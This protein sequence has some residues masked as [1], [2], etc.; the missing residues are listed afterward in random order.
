MKN[1]IPIPAFSNLYEEDPL[2]D[3]FWHYNM[4]EHF[5]AARERMTDIG[6][7]AAEATPFSARADKFGPVLHTHSADGELNER[8]EYHPDYIRLREL[9]YG[10]G[11]INI[12]YDAESLKRFGPVRHRLGFAMGYYFAQTEIG[13]YCPVCMTDGVGRVL[14]RH[15]RDPVCRETIRHLSSTNLNELWQGAMFLTEKQGGSDVGANTATAIQESGR[16]LISGGK[17]FCS[18]VDAD[19]ALVLARM[20]GAEPIGTKG[21]GLFLVLRQVPAEN[22]RTIRIHRLKDKLGVRSMPTGEVTLEKTEGYLIGGI[23]EGFK[24]MAEMLNLSRLYNSVASLA[25]SRRAILEAMAYGQERIAFGRPLRELPLWRS[26]MADLIAEHHALK[27]LT[28]ATAHYLDLA[29]GGDENAAKM[30]RLLTPLTKAI[31]GKF[32]IFAASEAMELIGG[33]GYIEESILPRVLRDCQVLP[34][35]EG[36]TNIL[37]LDGLRVLKKHGDSFFY[38]EV[39]RLLES[40]GADARAIQERVKSER[41]FLAG[42]E[43]LPADEQERAVRTWVE[44]A[45]RTFCLAS[46]LHSAGHAGL[47]AAS[48]A[49]FTRL[50]ARAACTSPLGASWN[51]DLAKTE[52]ALFDSAYRARPT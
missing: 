20:P 49:A 40:A 10:G 12:K 31:T 13:L 27:F 2:A 24:Q 9:G 26:T 47:S 28:F 25:G 1:N 6:S 21:L 18:N 14:E 33:N 51:P 50:S 16:W 7:R 11:L 34:I 38:G 4:G 41:R 5:G 48:N 17:W 30:V 3:A 19:A 22:F 39:E 42:L 45:S 36:T 44:S 29:D 35:W 8:V 46:L 37:S 52:E 23:G 15:G 43:K 32:A